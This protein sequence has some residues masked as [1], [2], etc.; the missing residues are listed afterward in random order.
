MAFV[1]IGAQARAPALYD[2]S[3]CDLTVA[4]QDKFG[5]AGRRMLVVGVNGCTSVTSEVTESAHPPEIERSPINLRSTER[6]RALSGPVDMLIA[7]CGTDNGHDVFWLRSPD[8]H[9]NEWTIVVSQARDHHWFHFD[10]GLA[11][12]LSAIM[13]GRK[14]AH[15]RRPD[16]GE[17]TSLRR[18]LQRL[19]HG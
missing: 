17:Y 10:G 1:L 18:A 19:N 13:S 5:E 2:R 15:V 8:T 3:S 7:V 11:A 4:L 16:P 9:P 14:P 6:A 12:F